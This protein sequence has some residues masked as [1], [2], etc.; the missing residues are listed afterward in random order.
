MALM[1]GLLAV[2]LAMVL[3]A[4]PAMAHSSMP[5]EKGGVKTEQTSVD[6]VSTADIFVPCALGGAGE[7]VQLS[8]N[9]IT[10]QKST[11]YPNGAFKLDIRVKYDGVVGVGLTSGEPYKVTS[12]M[13]ILQS[14]IVPFPYTYSYKTKLK[15]KGL[16]SKTKFRTYDSAE[17]VVDANGISTTTTLGSLIDC[18][19]KSE[20]DYSNDD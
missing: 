11:A 8:G 20:P 2:A 9:T 7:F 10:R 3:N 16:W 4:G 1:S 6:A 15:L 5:S 17:T 18:R 19:S 13:K 14:G 12:K